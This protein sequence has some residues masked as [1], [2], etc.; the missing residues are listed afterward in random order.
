[1]VQEVNS[2]INDPID[3][4]IA[5][6]DGNDPRFVNKLSCYI[7]QNGSDEIAKNHKTR[8][9]SVNEIQYCV[10]SILKFA[11]FVRNIFIITNGQKPEIAEII[12]ESFPG[13]SNSIRIVDHLEIF[14]GFEE[15]LPTFSSR[16][17]ETMIWRIEGLSD[18]FVYFNDDIFLIKEVKPADWFVNGRPVLRGN[19]VPIPVHKII[20][21]CIQ[22]L[23]TRFWNRLPS[24]FSRPSFHMGQWQSARILGYKIRYFRNWHTPHPFSKK[25]ME[26]FFYSNFDLIRRNISF[27]FRNHRQFSPVA[28]ANHLELKSGNNNIVG[29]SL[30]YVQPEGRR[31]DY[32]EKKTM[33]CIRNGDIKFMCVQSLELCTSEQQKKL[34]KWLDKIL[35]I[36]KT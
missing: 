13:R 10:L 33:K 9:A 24:F 1:M 4:V 19:W 25:R 6:V 31:E 7:N 34:F 16:S 30:S 26:D 3:V 23:L 18:S 28:L 29:P 20:W 36:S 17:I 35:G 21:D 5:W 8:F 2:G 22:R 11:P 12:E 27:R 15:F 32:I 14:M